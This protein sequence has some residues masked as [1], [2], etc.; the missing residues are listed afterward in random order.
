[1]KIINILSIIKLIIINY[2]HKINYLFTNTINKLC[3]Y[4]STKIFIIKS[5]L[6]LYFMAYKTF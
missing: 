1:M 3:W 2:S 4:N 6:Y 5:V